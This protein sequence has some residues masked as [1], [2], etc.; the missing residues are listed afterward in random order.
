MSDCCLVPILRA[1]SAISWREK[2]T[3]NEMIM[4]SALILNQRTEL[5]FHSASSLVDTP[6][7]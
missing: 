5:D 3:F 1:I 6:L 4:M 7:D 2:V